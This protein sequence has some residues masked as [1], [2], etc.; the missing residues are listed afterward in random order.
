MIAHVSTENETTTKPYP[1]T[2]AP[3]SFIM[4]TESSCT[5]RLNRL[6]R[7]TFLFLIFCFHEGKT[8]NNT[9]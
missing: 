6:S 1:H 4:C 9:Q 7:E 3:N 5:F 8:V 2:H